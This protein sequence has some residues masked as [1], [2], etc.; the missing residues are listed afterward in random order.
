MGRDSMRRAFL[1]ASKAAGL[2]VLARKLRQNTLTILCYHGFSLDDEHRYLPGMF[3][4]LDTLRRRM[5][6]LRDGGYRVI[7]LD[8]GV[9]RLSQGTLEPDSV[10]IT[11]DDGFY[12][13]L[14]VAAPVFREFGFPNTLYL[15]TYYVLHQTPIYNFLLINMLLRSE[16]E[17]VAV[18]HL[19]PGLPERIF[20]RGRPPT[21]AEW[22]KLARAI[23]AH[24]PLEARD[25]VFE[26]IGAALDVNYPSLRDRRLYHL[27]SPDEVRQISKL[28]VDIQLHTH[29]HRLPESRSDIIEEITRNRDVIGT[30]C[31]SSMSHLCYPSGEWKED[32]L[33][34]LEE[35]GVR[36]ATTCD[37]GENH[38][39]THP[40]KLLRVLDRDDIADI[41]FEAELSGYKPLLR[42]AM[43]RDALPPSA[44]KSTDA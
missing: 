35:L 26:Q 15:T 25:Q 39:T 22:I 23:D 34:V 24:Y 31:S 13:T 18:S 17:S 36:S 37:I 11:T 42:K 28:G 1:K 43:R 27:L 21:D 7:S 30:L 4:S 12:G 16:K 3:V 6:T 38:R 2:F 19:A 8:E 33:P 9:T 10:V 44:G 5:Q 41:E 32:H 20:V 29:R 14:A 40:L